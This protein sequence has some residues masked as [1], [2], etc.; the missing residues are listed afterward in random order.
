MRVLEVIANSVN[1]WLFMRNYST[2]VWQSNIVFAAVLCRW[3]DDEKHEQVTVIVLKSIHRSGRFPVAYHLLYVSDNIGQLIPV[4]TTSH[5]GEQVGVF[6]GIYD[7]GFVKFYSSS[8]AE[9]A[10]FVRYDH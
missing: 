1:D 9:F 2:L 10:V 6:I 7:A 5:N 4:G 8:V 3:Y